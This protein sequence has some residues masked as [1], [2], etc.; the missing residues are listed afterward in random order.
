MSQAV[1]P[2]PKFASSWLARWAS[3][4]TEELRQERAHPLG[5]VLLEEVAEVG[6]RDHL[7]V[8][9]VALHLRHRPRDVGQ[10]LVLLAVDGPHR[11]LKL[12]QRA[13]DLAKALRAQ[14]VACLGERPPG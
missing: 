7:G 9:D 11:P 5:I 12:G 14:A 13:F 6:E 10:D 3:S 2:G 4:W 8:R 1:R